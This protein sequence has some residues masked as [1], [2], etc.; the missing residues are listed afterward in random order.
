MRIRINEARKEAGLTQREL[1]TRLGISQPYLAQLERGE[2]ALSTVMQAR[3][4]SAIGVDPIEL[5]DFMAPD[6][7]E[8]EE[9]LDVFRRLS[10]E[11]RAG[12]IDMARAAKASGRKSKR[13]E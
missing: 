7:S 3:I 12:W 5:V 6:T 11:R 1:S 2:R 10:P 13:R 4:A 9:L 8:E